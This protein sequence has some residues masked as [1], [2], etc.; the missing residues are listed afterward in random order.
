MVEFVYTRKYI[1]IYIFMYMDGFNC[2]CFW[3]FILDFAVDI[4]ENGL[5]SIE[6]L[7]QLKIMW[8]FVTVSVCS[9]ILCLPLSSRQQHLFLVSKPDRT[10]ICSSRSRLHVWHLRTHLGFRDK[11]CGRRNCVFVFKT[12]INKDPNVKSES[13]AN[14]NDIFLCKT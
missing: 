10:Y 14:K 11:H 12:K 6:G 3:K 13:L 1:C 8:V 2:D 4:V 5:C 9:Q 7:T